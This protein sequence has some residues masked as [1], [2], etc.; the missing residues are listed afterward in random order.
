M[1]D[2]GFVVWCRG[3]GWFCLWRVVSVCVSG[4]DVWC[5]SGSA[6]LGMGRVCRYRGEYLLVLVCLG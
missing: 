2:V 6:D 1:Y 5:V 3:A 4:V